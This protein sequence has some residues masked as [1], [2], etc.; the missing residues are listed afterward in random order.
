MKQADPVIR[1]L[2]AIVGTGNVLYDKVSLSHYEYDAS[3]FKARPRAIAFA[4]DT[5]HV[6]QLVRYADQHAIPYVA[7]G[8]GTNLSGGTILKDGLI[9]EMRRMDQ[10]LD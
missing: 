7:R 4:T 6:A 5:D 2:E 8:S 3:L 10:I 1:D 9:I